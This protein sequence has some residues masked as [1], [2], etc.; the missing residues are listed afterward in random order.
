MSR[1]C[2][3]PVKHSEKMIPLPPRGSDQSDMPLAPSA[4]TSP[5]NFSHGQLFPWL[6]HSFL[7]A[8]QSSSTPA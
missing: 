2:L 3:R 5:G 1:T 4:G 7:T 8:S 6:L